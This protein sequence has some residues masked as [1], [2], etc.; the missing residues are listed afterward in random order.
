MRGRTEFGTERVIEVLK[1]SEEASAAQ[2]CE[3]VLEN[4]REFEHLSWKKKWLR[5]D[6]A[7]ED[8]TALTLVRS[9]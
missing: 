7:R 4:S 5:K 8:M 3:T 1:N 9:R 2:V 6:A